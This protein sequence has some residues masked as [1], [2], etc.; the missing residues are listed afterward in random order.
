MR[1]A[2]GCGRG[3]CGVGSATRVTDAVAAAVT[4]AAAFSS[5]GRSGRRLRVSTT[6][7]LVRPRPMSW[8]T[9]PWF[10][11]DGFRVRVFLPDT[12]SVLSSLL[13]VIQFP[14]LRTGP[15]DVHHTLSFNACTL[16][17]RPALA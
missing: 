9:V 4:G 15:D 12:L 5:S 14:F 2:G 17:R 13:S 16:M 1:G 10:T 6:T 8:R 11:P 7:A 3:G